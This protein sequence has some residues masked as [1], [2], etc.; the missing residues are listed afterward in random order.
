MLKCVECGKP[1]THLM[2]E[3]KLSPLC[4]EHFRQRLPHV[5]AINV[6]FV[7]LPL[8][9][10][11]LPRFIR[12]VNEKLEWYEEK[13]EQSD[14]EIRALHAEIRRLRKIAGLD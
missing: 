4:W 2:I 14:R 10:I 6:D 9:E 5:D 1:A 11:E 8:E 12:I 13:L 3:D 7:H